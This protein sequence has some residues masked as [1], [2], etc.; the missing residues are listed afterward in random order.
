MALFRPNKDVPK[1][2]TSPAMTDTFLR[3]FGFRIHSRPDRGPVMWERGGRVV[4]E[5][6]SY[7][8]C[9]SERQRM[10]R[11]LESL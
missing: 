8:L 2:V 11:Q 1:P 10:L 7:Q 5:E 6:K 4:T 3:E 9:L